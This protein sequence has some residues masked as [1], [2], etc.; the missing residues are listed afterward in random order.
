MKAGSI[1]IDSTLSNGY[2][3]VAKFETKDAVVIMCSNDEGSLGV[4]NYA[5]GVPNASMYAGRYFE[6]S[7]MSAR[8][9]QATVTYQQRCNTALM[10]QWSMLLDSS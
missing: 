10:E 9:Y 3:V 4:V 2:K 7:N 6:D 1:H 8:W 5:A